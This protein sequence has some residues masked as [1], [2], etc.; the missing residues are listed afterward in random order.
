ML[1]IRGGEIVEVGQPSYGRT[2]IRMCLESRRDELLEQTSDG[3]AIG[4]HPALLDYHVALFIK[5]AHH[6]VDEALG[7]EIGPQFETI[8]RK[9]IV[10]PGLVIIGKRVQAFASVAFH[11]L[12]KL[13]GHHIL[14]GDRKSTR[15]NSSHLGISYAVFCL[16][17][18]KKGWNQAKQYQK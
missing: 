17:K 9:G 5:F 16:K 12:A 2:M 11:D 10:I 18:K 14:V 1:R 13:I 15:L 3:P 6:G 7:L 4:T 8:F